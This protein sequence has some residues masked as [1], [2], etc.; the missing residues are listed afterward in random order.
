MFKKLKPE[1]W[2]AL[3]IGFLVSLLGQAAFC[4]EEIPGFEPGGVQAQKAE[5]EL[6]Q[7]YTP[8]QAEEVRQYLVQA[9][10][11]GKAGM[12]DIIARIKDGSIAGYDKTTRSIGLYLET[13]VLDEANKVR[14][15]VVARV[16]PYTP[17]DRAGV[18]PGDRLF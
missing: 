9:L 14:H 1:F 15:T 8:E 13:K 17:A 5:Q 4:Q 18:K 11:E 3:V 16:F 12:D 6:A 7:R 10:I 2:I